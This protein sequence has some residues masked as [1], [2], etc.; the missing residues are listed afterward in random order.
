[1]HT[2]NPSTQEAETRGSLSLW[3]AWSTERF[4]GQPEKLSLKIQQQQNKT[5]QK[6]NKTT[7]TRQTKHKTK[8]IWYTCFLEAAYK[9]CNEY[10]VRL[11]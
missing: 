8:S 3:S 5:K 4:P 1:M 7:K 6:Q 9:Y 10:R 2:F 11:T